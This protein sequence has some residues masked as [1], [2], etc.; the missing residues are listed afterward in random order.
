MSAAEERKVEDWTDAELEQLPVLWTQAPQLSTAEIGR[1]MHRSKSSVVGKA[2]R[3]NLPARP[4]PINHGMGK[5][6]KPRQLREGTTTLPPLPAPAADVAFAGAICQ[7]EAAVVQAFALPH[8]PASPAMEMPP[9]TTYKPLKAREC[10]Y[11]LWADNARPDGRFCRAPALEGKPYCE[12][13]RAVC[14]VK[15]PSRKAFTDRFAP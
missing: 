3:L 11:P 6:Q 5:A 8:L 2:H 9:A 10:C 13:H 1:R 7:I 14:W 4:S 15:V 12:T